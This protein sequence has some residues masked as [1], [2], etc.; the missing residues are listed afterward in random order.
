MDLDSEVQ[1]STAL[2]S[3]IKSYCPI[4]LREYFSFSFYFVKHLFPSRENDLTGSL[5]PVYISVRC[6][7]LIS[8]TSCMCNV[9]IF[10]LHS[11]E[12]GGT[13]MHLFPHQ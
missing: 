10:N 7:G 12:Y 6:T 13:G 11:V 5:S 9:F 3:S 1:L 4:E 2:F 8:C